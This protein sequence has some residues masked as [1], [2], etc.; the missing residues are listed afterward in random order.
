MGGGGGCV[1]D[2]FWG[3]GAS[4]RL[5]RRQRLQKT[6]ARVG[7]AVCENS[8]WRRCTRVA[9]RAQDARA[10][11]QL[12][13]GV[14]QGSLPHLPPA[15]RVVNLLAPRPFTLAVATRCSL[16]KVR[17]GRRC[18]PLP[19]G[20][21]PRARQAVAHFSCACTQVA[22]LS[23]RV[24]HGVAALGGDGAAG[25]DLVSLLA[26]LPVH[27]DVAAGWEAREGD[28]GAGAASWAGGAP[29]L[30]DVLSAAQLAEVVQL[31]AETVVELLA[32][33]QAARLRQ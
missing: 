18:P 11:L 31:E 28:G 6:V 23:A 3:A 19:R 30:S 29:R 9:W 15:L 24:R 33:D 1:S 10:L 5:W 4:V 20:P 25:E 22:L 27:R 12:A 17:R 26:T 32:H 13:S 16:A 14:V 21:G 2:V 8:G 7:S